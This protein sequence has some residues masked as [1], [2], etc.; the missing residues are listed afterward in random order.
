VPVISTWEEIEGTADAEIERAF[1][2]D[3]SPA[4]AAALATERTEEYFLIASFAGGARE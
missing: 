2:G 3:I 4:E 1:Y